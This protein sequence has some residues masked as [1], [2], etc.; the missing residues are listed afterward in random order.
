MY[1][2]QSINPDLGDFRPTLCTHGNQ[3]EPTRNSTKNS[4]GKISAAEKAANTARLL[5]MLAAQQSKEP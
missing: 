2:Q 5:A 3:P 1:S 4:S